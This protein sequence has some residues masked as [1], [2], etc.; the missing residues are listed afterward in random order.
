MNK[1]DEY[2]A[3]AAECERMAHFT[4]NASEKRTWLEMA[5]S[6][7]RL[8]QPSPPADVNRFDAIEPGGAG[9]LRSRTSTDCQPL[10]TV[11]RFEKASSASQQAMYA[12]PF[13]TSSHSEQK[14]RHRRQPCNAMR[15]V[16]PLSTG[17]NACGSIICFEMR[18]SMPTISN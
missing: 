8:I 13:G 4:R 11:N 7:L 2:R 16:A 14:D 12:G 10:R 17:D 6:W 9:E 1:N 5:E 3:N 15:I 18:R